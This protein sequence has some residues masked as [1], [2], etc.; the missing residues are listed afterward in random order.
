MTCWLGRMNRHG[1]KRTHRLPSIKDYMRP[2]LH[3]AHTAH[4]I[5][6]TRFWLVNFQC[7]LFRTIEN[8]YKFPGYSR[9]FSN[10]L[11]CLSR[12]TLIQNT[13]KS[14]I[15]RL[16]RCTNSRR[17]HLNFERERKTFKH[18]KQVEWCVRYL[19]WIVLNCP[20]VWLLNDFAYPK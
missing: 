7:L 2:T 16:I 15:S 18:F 17:H 9:V 11:L 12:P 4:R 19:L 1:P 20:N 10:E 8:V 6:Y 13:K 5:E 3:N 14:G